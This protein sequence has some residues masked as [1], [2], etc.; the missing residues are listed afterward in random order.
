LAQA[1]RAQEWPAKPVRLVSPYPPG[2]VADIAARLISA[3]LTDI[4]KQQVLVENRVGGGGVVGT[5]HVAKAAPDGYTFLVATVGE[6]TI[7]PHMYSKLSFNVSKDLAP[8]LFATDTPLMFAANAGAAFNNVKEMIA[9]SRSVAGGLSYAS[10]GLA[11]VNHVVAE[12]FALE[13]GAKLVHVPYKGGGPA[14]AALAGGEIPLG[15]VAVSSAAPHIKTGRVKAIGVT[16]AARVALGPDW[17]TVSET[18]P[19]FTA[20][21]WVGVAA[22]AGTP[23]AILDRLNEASAQALRSDA[24]RQVLERDGLLPMANS[25]VQAQQFLRNEFNKWDRIVR[26]KQLT[27][28]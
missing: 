18:M 8:V 12:R 4:W 23:T 16:A 22:P 1:A 24:M 2:G 19:G 3:K 28:D 10:P 9:Y 20:S 27:A 13:S 14:G 17:P 25:R 6:Y 21:N 5:E 11:T 7:T 26:D 15:M